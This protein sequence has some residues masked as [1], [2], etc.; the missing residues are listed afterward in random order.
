MMKKTVFSFITVLALCL[1]L[2]AC[3]TNEDNQRSAAPDASGIPN[4]QQN[5]RTS[6]TP[7]NQ[8]VVTD[9]NGI[10]GDAEDNHSDDD[11]N[12][13]GNA[14]EQ[15]GDTVNHAADKVGDTVSNITSNAGNIVSSVTSNVGD[16]VSN[17]ADN[18]GDVAEKAADNASEAADPSKQ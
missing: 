2:T 7:V 8:G 11:Q 9:K 13:V 15:I 4:A 17:I 14:A 3:K 16:S 1:S 18:A 5:N 12:P 10:I 6:E